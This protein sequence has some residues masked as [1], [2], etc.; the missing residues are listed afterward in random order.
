MATKHEGTKQ[1]GLGKKMNSEPQNRRITNIECR[2]VV[3]RC[4]VVFI[5]W[6]KYALLKEWI[7]LKKEYS[8]KKLKNESIQHSA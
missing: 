1:N 2:R 4:S 7:L 8:K 6:A 5:K 3:S